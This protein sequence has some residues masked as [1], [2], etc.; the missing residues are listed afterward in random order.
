[1]NTKRTIFIISVLGFM[2]PMHVMAVGWVITPGIEVAETYLDNVTLV[3][4]N[5]I[6]DFVTEINPSLSISR[7]SRGLTVLTEYT[8]QNTFYS[9]ESDFNDTYHDFMGHVNANLI[10][11]I[12]YVELNGEYG[13]QNIS[14]EDPLSTGNLNVTGNRTNVTSARIKPY[15]DYNI[16]RY[17]NLNAGVE[18]GT[19]RYD[20]SSLS[21][22][23]LTRY[24]FDLTSGPKFNR[25]GWSANFY[26]NEIDYDQQPDSTLQSSSATL[27]YQ[28]T[29][30]IQLL[31]SGGY[32]DNDFVTGPTVTDGTSGS[33]WTV[34]AQWQPSPTT[35]LE[36][37]IGER[38]F[39]NTGS[40][41]F[42][43]RG[44][45]TNIA[46][47][48]LED[49]TVSSNNQFGTT[50]F[51]ASDQF[52][53]PID[54][55]QPADPAATDPSAVGSDLSG[56][57]ITSEFYIRK[58]FQADFQFDTAKTTFVLNGYKE[59][60]EF[61]SSGI[62]DKTTGINGSV[63]WRLSSRTTGILSGTWSNIDFGGSTRE[64]DLYDLSV[65]VT[66][67]FKRNLTGLIGYGYLDRDSNVAGNDY[68]QNT[69]RISLKWTYR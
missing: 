65:Y 48:Y 68:T 1:M 67:L 7:V 29:R 5:E 54:P 28:A 61:Q 25:L 10:R 2:Q 40:L 41:L 39:G 49:I 3:E 8:M 52:G 42:T 33:F 55:V 19:V 30:Q 15:V 50:L 32:D 21:N 66:Y 6:D 24:N 27:S 44:R 14:N 12:F 31:V 62:T 23:D 20:D 45:R 43:K 13:Q 4:N 34:G 58:R 9:D 64:D 63:D 69:G 60:R 16:K 51:P 35:F 59:D 37:K 38:Y 18:L 46:V 17:A 47:I 11:D 22:S 36:A 53:N 57:S 56:T 26:R